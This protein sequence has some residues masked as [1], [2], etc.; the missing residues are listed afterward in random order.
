M[1]RMKRLIFT[2]TVLVVAMFIGTTLLT[3]GSYGYIPITSVTRTNTNIA[4]YN[5]NSSQKDSEGYVK[6]TSYLINNTL[7]NGNFINTSNSFASNSFGPIGIAIGTYNRYVYVTNYGPGSVSI[8]STS[9]AP[10]VKYYTVTFKELG[11]QPG[12]SWTVTLNGTTESSTTNIL[13]FTIVN[14]TYT[15]SIGSTSGYTATPLSG[16]I[17]VKGA[18]VS[19]SI[20]FTPPPVSVPPTP[21][22]ILPNYLA[23]IVMVYVLVVIA[24][25]IIVVG[26]GMAIRRIKK[27]DEQK[28]KKESP[29]QQ[30]PQQ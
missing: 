26:V 18:N 15:Y 12:A 11:L 9:T 1:K 27:K 24:V 17:T 5:L 16:N 30:P 13:N 6:Y 23:Y 4:S 21:P 28:Q 8:I 29:K 2:T 3:T 22:S 25:I 19:L 14:G 10:S 7:I 20:L